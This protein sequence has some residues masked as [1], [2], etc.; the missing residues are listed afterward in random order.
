[1]LELFLLE[2]CNRNW[3]HNGHSTVAELTAPPEPTKQEVH[4]TVSSD[5]VELKP[6]VKFW[7]TT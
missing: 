4:D 1:M 5:L 3:C 7:V 2:N 6:D